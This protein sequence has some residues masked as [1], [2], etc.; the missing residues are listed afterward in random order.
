MA[1]TTGAEFFD[2]IIADRTVI[3]PDNR[4][5]YSERVVYMPDCYQVNNDG[6]PIASTAFKR[7]ELGL[8]D[9][10]F[11][12]C[13]FNR[14]YKIDPILFDC[15]MRILAKVPESV[16]WLQAGKESVKRNLWSEAEKRGVA[17]HRIVF[18]V[19]LPKPEHLSRLKV[20]DLALDTR[21]VSGAA[22]TSDA[23]WAGLPVITVQGNHFASR[24]TSSILK[25]IEL[26]ELILNDL[27]GYERKAIA[28]ARSPEELERVKRKLA[29][30]RHS[31]SLFD[32]RGFTKNMERAYET[33]WQRY[34]DCLPPQHILT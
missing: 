30:N 6:Q 21:L 29:A 32:T 1:G 18:A 7:E 17:A 11:I 25:A 28:L 2:Y 12:F 8:P 4:V 31:R 13:S 26:P 15:W 10:V 5:H 20:A 24:M 3:P 9:E 19:R 34:I 22:T 14:P 33:M 27:I 23:L 16:L